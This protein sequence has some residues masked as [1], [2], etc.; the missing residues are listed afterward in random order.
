VVCSRFF[1]KR[2]PQ[3]QTSR[4]PLLWV[5][6]KCTSC[7]REAR[8]HS[9]QS[10][11]IICNTVATLLS[12]AAMLLPVAPSHRR[13]EI[14]PIAQS[15]GYRHPPKHCHTHTAPHVDVGLL[16]LQKKCRRTLEFLQCAF[17]RENAVTLSRSTD[18]LSAVASAVM[19]DASGANG[20]SESR[21]KRLKSSP[22]A[23]KT[24]MRNT[25]PLVCA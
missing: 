11:S 25:N 6:S 18:L 20:A 24:H 17:T 22:P 10:A 3:C 1:C 21:A 14:E 4:V 13:H 9:L 19:A 8:E 16:V 12:L 23:S 15:R 7:S 2:G 5:A